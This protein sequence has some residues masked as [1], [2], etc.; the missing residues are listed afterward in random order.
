MAETELQIAA[1]EA[2]DQKQAVLR[3]QAVVLG[4]KREGGARL[5]KATELL[6]LMQ[7]RVAYQGSAFGATGFQRMKNCGELQGL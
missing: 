3:Q 4:L 1:R 5:E 2:S 7:G 6:E